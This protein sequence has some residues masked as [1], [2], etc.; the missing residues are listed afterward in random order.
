MSSIHCCWSST[1]CPL[2]ALKCTWGAA[3]LHTNGCT[4]HTPHAG[5]PPPVQNCGGE[6]VDL[7]SKSLG[8]FGKFYRPI[9]RRNSK[10]DIAA[11]FGA[12]AGRN[13]GVPRRHRVI[14]LVW[15]HGLKQLDLMPTVGVKTATFDATKYPL[16][17]LPAAGTKAGSFDD[18]LDMFDSNPEK[19]DVHEVYR[20]IDHRFVSI[21]G[22]RHK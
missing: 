15:N 11:A 13:H 2:D 21:P 7:E 18:P 14:E 3:V 9:E 20:L 17:S 19:L 12:Y 16:R 10:L 22:S 4:N 1:L 5:G 8:A 6:P